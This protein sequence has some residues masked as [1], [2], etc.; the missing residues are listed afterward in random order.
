MNTSQLLA[1][2]VQHHQTGAFAQAE[3]LYREL[4]AADPANADALHLLGVL[5][6]QTGRSQAAVELIRRAIAVDS[7]IPV[8]HLNLAI[9]LQELGRIDEAIESCKTALRLDPEMPEAY[10]NLGVLYLERRDFAQAAQCFQ[11]A[12]QRRPDHPEACGNLGTALRQ[13]GRTD[14][15]IQ[16]YL[17]ALQLRPGNAAV[18]NNLGAALKEAGRLEEAEIQL[19]AALAQK[20][21][22]LQALNNLGNVLLAQGRRE[23]AVACYQQALSLDPA[24]ADAYLHLGNALKEAGRLEEAIKSYGTALKQKPGSAEARWNLA[25]ANLLAGRLAEGWRDFDLRERFQK[26]Y[27]HT[28]HKPRWDGSAFHGKTLLVHDEIGYG[29]VFQFL[30][31]LPLAKARGGRV[32]F[33]GKPGLARLLA[34]FPGIDE[35]RERSAVPVPEALFDLYVPMESLPGILGTT[36][37]TIPP[38]SPPLLPPPAVAEKWR[39]R[40]A[41]VPGI[42][43]GIVWSGNPASRYDIARSC[44][45]ADFAPLAAIAGVT[46]ISLQKG[47]SADEADNPPMPVLVLSGELADFA[48]T[49]GIIE[50][51][52]LVITVETSVAHLAGAMGKNVWVLLPFVPAWRWFMG[53][54]DSPWYPGVRL[55]R[56]PQPGDWAGVFA[57]VGAALSARVNSGMGISG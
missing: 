43:A 16:A 26:I 40:L 46:W 44:H 56:Q 18:L 48:E 30:R 37:Q 14:E 12:I 19:R 23:E 35:L 6:S 53:R 36:L 39:T 29:D 28:Y 55:F 32:I 15:A 3:T 10:N 33:E 42:K 8:F 38:Q 57:R 13:L 47:P 54:E 5:S 52:D 11:A 34:G 17:R 4:L 25:L 2:A 9:A 51:L 49:A 22:Y 41:G 21:D 50:Q 7:G 20:P 1:A 45:L 31:Y 27:P 24:Y